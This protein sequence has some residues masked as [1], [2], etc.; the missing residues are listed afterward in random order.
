MLGQATAVI[1]ND[2][3]AVDSYALN[4]AG[5]GSGYVVVSVGNGRAFT[6]VDEPV[7]LSVFKVAAP[8][9][10]GELKVV[11]P[12]N[13]LDEK[14]TLRHSLDFA[15]NPADYEFQWLYAPPVDGAPPVLY[16]YTAASG[17]L[18]SGTSK[19]YNQPGTD[20]AL[21]RLPEASPSTT[22]ISAGTTVNAL[23]VAVTINDSGDT[24]GVHGV[25]R[26][27]AV[28]R[29]QFDVATLPLKAYLSVQLGNRDG[30]EIYL[31][32]SLV[33]VVNRDPARNTA[34]TATP[35]GFSLTSSRRKFSTASHFG[36]PRRL[37]SSS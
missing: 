8:L 23:P 33:A 3:T 7:S 32:E 13:P 1:S 20:F 9:Y 5:G 11:A 36:A 35:T 14:I 19:L 37:P 6:P 30:A 24:V 12:S 15:G 22:P 16:T 26:P 27:Q 29:K 17:L 18:G 10:R 34:V 4:A 25:S 21:L 2:D 28:V 31:N